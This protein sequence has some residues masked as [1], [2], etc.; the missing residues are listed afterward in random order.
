MQVEDYIN[1]IAD[2]SEQ[3]AL[4]ALLDHINERTATFPLRVAGTTVVASAAELDL[5]DGCSRTTAEINALL[6]CAT[7]Q[8][9]VV[10]GT[11]GIIATTNVVTGLSTVAGFF[12]NIQASTFDT[13]HQV[14]WRESYEAGR[15]TIYGWQQST[16]A[17]TIH[18]ANLAL[19]GSSSIEYLAIGAA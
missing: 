10:T 16:T 15:V 7:A 8:Y 11:V 13:L 5:M 14:T 17:G 18:V 3:R 9:K 4:Q 1:R 6:Q 19:G 12:A 2:P